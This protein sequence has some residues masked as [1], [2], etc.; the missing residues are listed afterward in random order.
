MGYAAPR[1]EHAANLEPRPLAARHLDG[2]TRLADDVLDDREPEAGATRRAGAVGPVE[3]LEQPRQLLLVDAHAVVGAAEHDRAVPALDGE[4]EGGAGACVADRVL[5]QVLADH[6][7]H[8]RS[9]LELDLL[10]AFD[11]DRHPRAGGALLELGRGDVELGPHGHGPER[12]DAT[13]RLELREEQHLVDQLAH[14]L[15][16]GAGPVDE[17]VHVLARQRRRLEQREQARER[18]PQLVGDRRREPRP[19]LLVG[20]HVAGL[21][22]VDDS[23]APPAQVVRHDQRHGPEVAGEETVGNPLALVDPVDRL[24]GPPAREQDGVAVVDDD[25]GLPALL[26]QH[27]GAAGVV[28]HARDVLTEAGRAALLARPA[29]VLFST[30]LPSGHN[31]TAPG[32]P[33]AVHDLTQWRRS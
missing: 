30:S 33:A 19:Q 3:A 23:L 14:R 29:A 11:H 2:A 1:R 7:Q 17:R 9:H 22:E 20:G 26:D 27:T 32:E 24:P 16:L 8:P 10:V 25:H 28:V 6:P 21:A 15:D 5:R 13:A 18:R 4:R 12:D 31:L